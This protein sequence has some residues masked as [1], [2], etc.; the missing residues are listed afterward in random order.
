MPSKNVSEWKNGIFAPSIAKGRYYYFV[1]VW[2][3]TLKRRYYC[4]NNSS[5]NSSRTINKMHVTD[6]IVQNSETNIF[7]FILHIQST[8]FYYSV[9]IG[10]YILCMCS[11]RY[12][13]YIL[14][15][16]DELKYRRVNYEASY[17]ML[18]VVVA[19]LCA[20]SVTQYA[21]LDN[22]KLIVMT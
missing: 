7:H 2:N 9:H 1:C 14:P 8:L 22:T 16:P 6:F 13:A 5:S 21:W 19:V 4:N 18:L 20:R 11:I 10:H 17:F 12:S 15:E 3:E